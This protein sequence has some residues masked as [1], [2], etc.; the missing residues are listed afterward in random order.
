MKNSEPLYKQLP[1]REPCIGGFIILY[2][3]REFGLRYEDFS[4]FGFGKNTIEQWATGRARPRFDD[5]LLIC[6]H[7]NKDVGLAV[8]IAKLLRQ[9]YRSERDAT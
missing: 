7:Y 2:I 6:D 5:V 3:K 8:T 9:R 4:F 1:I